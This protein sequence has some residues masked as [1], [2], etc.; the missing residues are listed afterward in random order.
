MPLSRSLGFLTGL[1][2]LTRPPAGTMASFGPK[3]GSGQLMRCGTEFWGFFHSL[4]SP[5]SQ[6]L[7]GSGP[8]PPPLSLRCR[9]R[10]RASVT[11]PTDVEDW[12]RLAAARHRSVALRILIL[13]AYLGQVEEPEAGL[14]EFISTDEV[15]VLDE[16][17]PQMEWRPRLELRPNLWWV[18][19]IDQEGSKLLSPFSGRLDGKGRQGP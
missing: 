2:G 9:C 3:N 6:A 4:R 12:L 15:S 13:L 16:H 19:T 17:P 18:R 1:T 8:F 7:P 10:C 5:E 14:P 11:S